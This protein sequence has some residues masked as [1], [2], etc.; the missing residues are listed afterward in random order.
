VLMLKGILAGLVQMAFLTA[1]LFLP[2]GTMSWPRAIAFLSAYGIVIL[3]SIIWLAL[4]APE[5]LEARFEMPDG[6]QPR[7]DR[8]ISVLLI[9]AIAAF[10]FTIPIDRFH[11]HLLP[12]PTLAVS[13]FGAVIAATGYALLII[14]LHQN[15]FAV[16][17]VKDQQDKGQHVIDTGLYGIVRHPFYAGLLLFLAG[18]AL[19]LESYAALLVLSSVLIVLV[20]RTLIEEESLQETLPGYIEYQSR[21]R[22]RL[23]PFVW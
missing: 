10:L 3:G 4:T 22:Y 17:M 1:A 5:S 11:L 19:W 2:A 13:I 8:I 12:L 14:A 20:G 7:A 16:S 15:P 6:T 21:V 18:I 23:I 9:L